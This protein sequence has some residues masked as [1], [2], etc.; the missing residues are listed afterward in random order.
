MICGLADSA[1]ADYTPPED[2]SQPKANP[3]DAQIE[4]LKLEIKKIE[5]EI[6]VHQAAQQINEEASTEK[7]QKE[8]A[9]LARQVQSFQRSLEHEQK[10][11]KHFETEIA[12]KEGKYAEQQQQLAT[13]PDS[14]FYDEQVATLKAQ[15]DQLEQE[16]KDLHRDIANEVGED[17][18]IDE[19]LKAGST[20]KQ[21]NEKLQR[22]NAECAKL[23]SQAVD[24]RVKSAVEGAADKVNKG[25]DQLLERKAQLEVS[26]DTMK[27]KINRNR[28]K[29]DELEEENRGLRMM[30]VLLAEKLKHDEDLIKHLQQIHASDP[31]KVELPEEDTPPVTEELVAQLRAQQNIIKGLLYKLG[32]AQRELAEYTVPS[33]FEYLVDQLGQLNQRCMILQKNLVK[34]EAAE[35]AKIEKHIGEE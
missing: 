20:A 9:D 25:L 11:V 12:K 14:E 26:N 15:N 27:N 22:L 32:V 3:L 18:D 4:A 17:F 31:T 24:S 8:I 28:T 2:P 34:R 29:C 19:L 7:K 6:Q 23:K 16:L 30:D 1:Y 13:Q 21:R 35:T 5:H 33:A 10:R